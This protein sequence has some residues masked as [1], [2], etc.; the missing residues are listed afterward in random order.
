MSTGRKVLNSRHSSEPII[1]WYGI[2][3]DSSPNMPNSKLSEILFKPI[4]V[5]Y[6]LTSDSLDLSSRKSEYDRDFIKLLTDDR[7]T[8]QV[9]SLTSKGEQYYSGLHLG[10]RQRR[11]ISCRDT[12]QDYNLPRDYASL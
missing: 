1:L 8:M 12:S 9:D 4:S 11:S 6:V 7:K 3:R 2:H 5:E 10:E